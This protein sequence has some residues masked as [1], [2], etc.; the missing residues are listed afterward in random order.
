MLIANIPFEPFRNGEEWASS[1][2]QFRASSAILGR[3]SGSPFLPARDSTVLR[4]Q[5]A[6]K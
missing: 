2:A 1:G 6:P 5:I 3:C 4:H